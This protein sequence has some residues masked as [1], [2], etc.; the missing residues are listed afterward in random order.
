MR[1][2]VQEHERKSQDRDEVPCLPIFPPPCV[3]NSSENDW[4]SQTSVESIFYGKYS[5]SHPNLDVTQSRS[6]AMEM[7]PLR[8]S[9]SIA[10]KSKTIFAWSEA[11]QCKY[12]KRT[13][14]LLRLHR[15][16]QSSG[17]GCVWQ[18]SD[19]TFD[20]AEIRAAI[21]LSAFPKSDERTAPRKLG[22]PHCIQIEEGR[23]PTQY[24]KHCN[25]EKPDR[26]HE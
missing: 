23:D 1:L 4:C 26:H 8:T 15:D 20:F 18:S 16:F 7:R 2:E 11:S 25:C 13:P 21:K 14:K 12:Q 24:T 10:S 9:I 17:K 3:L 19:G 6:K 22:P 5:H